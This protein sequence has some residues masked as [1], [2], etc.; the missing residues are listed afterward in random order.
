MI[1]VPGLDWRRSSHCAHDSCL[2]VARRGSEIFVR[3]SKTSE[4][5]MLAFHQAEWAEFLEG[6][7][8]GQFNLPSGT[9]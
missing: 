6:A 8:R 9:T 5:P 4:G 1:D 3:D 7:R 2:E